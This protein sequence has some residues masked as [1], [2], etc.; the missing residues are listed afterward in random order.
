MRNDRQTDKPTN[1]H[2]HTHTLRLPGQV[3]AVRLLVDKVSQFQEKET[4]S[5]G[6]CTV[7]VREYINMSID[8]IPNN[9]ACT[10]TSN[11]TRSSSSSNS[12]NVVLIANKE[13]S[14]TKDVEPVMPEGAELQVPVL[15]PSAELQT[16]ANSEKGSDDD[17]NSNLRGALVGISAIDIAI[18]NGHTE[19]VCMLREASA[20]K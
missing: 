9:A 17:R 11:S 19:I 2:K 10:S 15:K 12:S 7:S 6:A 20:L 5:R 1:T 14:G 16:E 8:L 3:E 4:Q 13:E 18:R